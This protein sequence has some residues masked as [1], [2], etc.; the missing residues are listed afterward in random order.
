MAVSLSVD[1]RA[2]RQAAEF[3]ERVLPHLPPELYL[4]WVLDG[5]EAEPPQLPPRSRPRQL[6]GEEGGPAPQ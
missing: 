6:A 5:V 2:A 4:L 1:L 3:R